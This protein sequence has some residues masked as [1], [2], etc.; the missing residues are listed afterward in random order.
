MNLTPRWCQ[1][2][3]EGG[4]EAVHWSQLGGGGAAD[5]E[6]MA[7][8]KAQS[9]IVLTHDLD[10]G[11][12]LAAT[13]HQSP[14]VVQIRAEDASPEAIGASVLAALRQLAGEIEAG[15]LV[16]IDPARARVRLLQLRR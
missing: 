5:A 9:L 1:R 16:T 15:A 3:V 14:S 13:G 6:I 4:H 10:I 2:L 11:A 12:I 7:Y 8:A